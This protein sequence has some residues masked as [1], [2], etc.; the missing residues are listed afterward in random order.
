MNSDISSSK[1]G[2]CYFVSAAAAFPFD[3]LFLIKDALRLFLYIFFQNFQKWTLLKKLRVTNLLVYL[4]ANAVFTYVFASLNRTQMPSLIFEI[5][6]LSFLGEC[7]RRSS[8][9]NSEIHHL[10]N[11]ITY[12]VVILFWLVL[13]SIFLINDKIGIGPAAISRCFKMLQDASRCYRIL[14]SF[15]FSEKRTLLKM[16]W[17]TF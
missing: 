7:L 4:V 10:M 6:F 1:F 2:Q 9:E 17:N 5:V 11:W 13:Q 15:E 8:E 3:S 12:S 16:S 14:I